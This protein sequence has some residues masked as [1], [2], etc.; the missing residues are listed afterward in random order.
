MSLNTCKLLR[1]ETEIRANEDD[2]NDRY[3]ESDFDFENE[4]RPI[5][6]GKQFWNQTFADDVEVKIDE[7]R[8]LL[9]L[10][11]DPGDAYSADS[12]ALFDDS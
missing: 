12:P 5:W 11:D 8:Q 9:D 1:N 7:I 3:D 6:L 2:P 10:S 4:I